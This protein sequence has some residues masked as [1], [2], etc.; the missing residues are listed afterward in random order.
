MRELLLFCL[1]IQRRLHDLRQSRHFEDAHAAGVVDG[2]ENCRVRSRQRRLADTRR[3]KRSQ[4]TRC[5]LEDDL[6]IV[7][8]VADIRQP[9]RLEAG[10]NLQVLE[11]FTEGESNTLCK[12]SINL[13]FDG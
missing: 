5:F 13:A 8:N 10:V 7:G 9:A 11:V 12:A 6:D 1:R 2:V 3:A 4:R